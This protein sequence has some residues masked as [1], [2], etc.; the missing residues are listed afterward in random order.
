MKY[1][2][3]P[4]YSTRFDC[5]RTSQNYKLIDGF[6]RPKLIFRLS[7]DFDLPSNVSSFENVKIWQLLIHLVTSLRAVAHSN[8]SSG[9]LNLFH[10]FK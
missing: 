8:L 9:I 2:T 3:N 6:L 7:A 5:G 10:L 4:P 1:K